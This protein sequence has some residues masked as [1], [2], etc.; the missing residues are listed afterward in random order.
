TTHRTHR[1]SPRA[2]TATDE[3]FH[4][5]HP[6]R[7]RKNSGRRERHRHGQREGLAERPANSRPYPSFPGGSILEYAAPGEEIRPRHPDFSTLSGTHPSTTPR[8][9]APRNSG[10]GNPTHGNSGP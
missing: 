6:D 10:P 8:N 3:E 5:L 7:T 2:P 9:H 1:F 4:Q